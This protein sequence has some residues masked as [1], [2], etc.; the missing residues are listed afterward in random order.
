MPNC[1]DTLHVLEA[2]R[3]SNQCPAKEKYQ[4]VFSVTEIVINCAGNHP[5]SG[6]VDSF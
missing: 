6:I 5:A 2:N 1:E 3:W 4:G